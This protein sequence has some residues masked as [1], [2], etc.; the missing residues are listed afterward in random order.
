MQIVVQST[1]PKTKSALMVI[2]YL[3]YDIVIVKKPLQGKV[4]F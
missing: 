1:I 2:I 4:S 3:E